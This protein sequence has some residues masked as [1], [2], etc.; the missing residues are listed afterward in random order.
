MTHWS[1]LDRTASELLEAFAAGGM[2]P[3][4]GSAAAFAGALA[5]SLIQAAARYA[6]KAAGRGGGSAFLARAEAILEEAR[7]RSRRL[8]R[9]VDE[10]AAAFERYWRDRTDEALQPAIDVPLGIAGECAALGWLGL[11]LYDRGARSA[12]GEAGT[13]L[14]TAVASGEAAVSIARFNL[15]AAR[16]PSWL[17]SRKERIQALAGALA[18]LRR[19]V[20]MR[21]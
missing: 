13:S 2:T 19:E 11:E 15:G 4:A 21:M 16:E 17:E 3:G 14:L 6:I 9:A 20:R 18:E 5:G 8:S 7:E 12:R 10:D 1:L